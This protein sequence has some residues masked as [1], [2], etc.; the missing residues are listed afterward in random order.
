LKAAFDSH[1]HVPLPQMID[2]WMIEPVHQ[3]ARALW[4]WGAG[5]VGRAVVNVL[6]PLPDVATTWVD[7]D[8]ARFPAQVAPQINTIAAA[9]PAKL[10][11]YASQNAEHLILTYSHDLDLELCHQLLRRSFRFAGLIGSAT[12]WARFRSRLAALGHSPEAVSRI[13]CPI[14]NPDHGKHPQ[15]IAIGVAEAF[16]RS[17]HMALD[18]K[19]T[20]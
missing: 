14:G 15:A 10:V 18:M 9:H 17:D 8:S 11:A 3:P 16:L 1:G 4:V 20:A 5:H 12:K 7:T 2:G 19:G 6:A 13:T